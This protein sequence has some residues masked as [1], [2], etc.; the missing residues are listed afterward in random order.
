MTTTKRISICL[1]FLLV[2]PFAQS[3][4]Y[5]L[6]EGNFT[7]SEAKLDSERRGGHLATITSEEEWRTVTGLFGNNLLDAFLGGTD[8]AQ[9]GVWKWITGEPWGFAKWHSGQPDNSSGV[10]DY[11]W[12]HP[13]Y[14]LEW[15]DADGNSKSKYLLE[16][17][18]PPRLPIQIDFVTVG[19]PGN[20]ADST[21]Y[22]KVDYVF[23]IGKFEINNLQYAAFLNAKA[24]SDAHSLYNS[25]ATPNNGIVRSGID[26]A[27][28]YSIKSGMEHKPVTWVNFY[29]AMRFANWLHNGG[30]NS[31]DTETGAYT[32]G[33]NG[34]LPTKRNPGAKYF[35]P[36][37]N[38]WYK[39]A[40]YQPASAGGPPGNYW[41]Y[42]TRSSNAPIAESPPGGS[43]SANYDVALLTNPEFTSLADVGAYVVAR[44]YYG[45]FDQTGNVW[46]WN[47][48][49]LLGGRSIRGGSPGEPASKISSLFRFDNFNDGAGWEQGCC[50][51]RLAAAF[52]PVEPLTVGQ[53]ATTQIN[54]PGEWRPLVVGQLVASPST[55]TGPSSYW[56]VIPDALRN[57]AL[58][59]YYL[60]TDITK[61]A[62]EDY[63]QIDFQALNSG[64][65]W[66][67]VLFRSGNEA[68]YATLQANGWRVLSR[69]LESEYGYDLFGQN[70]NLQTWMLFE[71]ICISGEKFSLRTETYQPPVI[72]RNRPTDS[73][74]QPPLINAFTLSRLAFSVI[75]GL[76]IPLS[77]PDRTAFTIETSIDLR[78]WSPVITFPTNSGA[79]EF[80]DSSSV[81]HSMRFYRAIK[82]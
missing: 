13:A 32:F 47:E 59:H 1:L 39:A 3:S 34:A 80:I 75:Q 53:L 10:Q 52:P 17:E 73:P 33:S 76:R 72:L 12:L 61:R 62:L 74:P 66:M 51:F 43:N 20:P 26:G 21:G 44:S 8:E 38:E 45:T 2:S 78:N 79:F 35:I 23:Q 18:S 29:K 7:W 11:L 64:P 49:A 25:T 4:T 30:L 5:Q 68:A 9:E 82:R 81:G 48:T 67:L 77:P 19:D 24:K 36:S 15:D 42:A 56:R 57:S 65:V 28:S 46:E 71:R 31:S 37:E 14:G 16:I 50:G 58:D 27:F 69:D 70:R 55:G 63:G 6:I 54:E 40:Y 41:L 60:T 22:G